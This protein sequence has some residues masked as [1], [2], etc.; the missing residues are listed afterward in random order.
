MSKIIVHLEDRAFM[1]IL[2]SSVEA[3]PSKY[4]LG[5]SRS[6]N[7]IP[8]EG[9][10]S[11]LL[12]GQR[13]TK[14]SKEVFNITLAMPS[15]IINE[16]SPDGITA[17]SKHIDLIKDLANMFPVYQFLGSYHSHPWRSSEFNWKK[18]PIFT[19][20]VFDKKHS[21]NPSPTDDKSSINAALVMKEN[22]LEIIL[23]ITCLQK[24]STINPEFIENHL[25]HNCCGRYKYSLASF[26]TK[27]ECNKLVPVDNLVCPTAA[28][29]HHMDFSD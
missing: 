23:G 29:M 8:N 3:F 18:K 22:L 25:I 9:E 2:L 28:G 6:E 7:G 4:R 15:Q 24:K 14:G 26:I 20:E 10:V 19:D 5:K 27:T 21:T 1:T 11:G 16:R 12:F 17:S 13:L